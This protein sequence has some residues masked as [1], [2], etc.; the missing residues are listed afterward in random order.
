MTAGLG[1]GR[2]LIACLMG[3]GLGLFFGFLRPLGRKAD[4]IFLL[5]AFW[6]WLELGFRVC[7]GDLRLVYT[8]GLF[9]GALVC[10][11][12]V[13][14]LLSGIFSAFWRILGRFME[15]FSHPGK[16]FQKK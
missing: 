5:G 8:F 7:R 10:H 16:F 15:K 1:A 12:T 3:V 11:W 2:F 6:C 13:G 14:G 9:A 4:G